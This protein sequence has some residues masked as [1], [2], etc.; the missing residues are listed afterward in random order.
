MHNRLFFIPVLALIFL[1]SATDARSQDTS[2]VFF[3]G[4][5]LSVE[6]AISTALQNNFDIM[7]SRNDSAVAALD[8]SYRD[9]AFYPRINGNST[10][11]FNNNNQQQTLADG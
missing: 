2:T 11:L 3:Q 5:T 10:I 6:Q 8:Y 9:Y 1:V 4:D 7:L